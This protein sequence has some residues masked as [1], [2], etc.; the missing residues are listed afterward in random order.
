MNNDV[1]SSHLDGGASLGETLTHREHAAAYLSASD[2]VSLGHAVF[3]RGGAYL[4]PAVAARLAN[5]GLVRILKTSPAGIPFARAT[6]N[7]RAA[8]GR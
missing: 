7:G 2:I 5:A 8:V 3:S 4:N 1:A 6:A